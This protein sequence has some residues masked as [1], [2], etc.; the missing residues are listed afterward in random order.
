MKLCKFAPFSKLSLGVA[1]LLY[2]L[3]YALTLDLSD[4]VRF[5]VYWQFCVLLFCE[6]PD[7][8]VYLT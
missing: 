5:D 8:D 6:L 4:L 3:V 7:W 2:T 1:L